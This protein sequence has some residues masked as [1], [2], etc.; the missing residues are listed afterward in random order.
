[1]PRCPP[2]PAPVP[3]PR[4]GSRP[5]HY[6]GGCSLPC[7]PSRRWPACGPLP[8][9]DPPRGEPRA[10]MCRYTRQLLSPQLPLESGGQP[11]PPWSPLRVP[12]PRPLRAPQSTS[13]LRFAGKILPV[14]FALVGG[15]TPHPAFGFLGD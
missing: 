7:T 12:S 9:F 2:T 13:A 11:V 14:A 3:P 8:V 4:R 10:A 5:T 1:T 15:G 6:T